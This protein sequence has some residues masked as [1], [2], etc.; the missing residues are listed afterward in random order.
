MLATKRKSDVSIP[1]QHV[2]YAQRP[3]GGV[4]LQ[5]SRKQCPSGPDGMYPCTGFDLKRDELICDSGKYLAALEE[6]MNN[7]ELALRRSR[8]GQEPKDNPQEDESPDEPQDMSSVSKSETWCFHPRK[9]PC[10]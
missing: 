6:R 1:S 5:E 4:H 3:V 8:E 9:K 2:N 7:M 10:V